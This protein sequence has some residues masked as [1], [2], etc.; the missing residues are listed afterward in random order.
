[1]L[2]PCAQYEALEACQNA[3]REHGQAS[4][5]DTDPGNSNEDDEN[6]EE[7]FS[8]VA[9]HALYDDQMVMTLNVLREL[10]NDTIKDIGCTIRKP[11]GDAQ[12]FQIAVCV[13]PQALCLLG[14]THVADL[15]GC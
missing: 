4:D 7:V 13:L 10:N 14:N 1:M 6:K 8:P 11:G 2:M 12:G 15:K 3:Q 9:A 5:K